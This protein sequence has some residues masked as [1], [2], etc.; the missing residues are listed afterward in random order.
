MQF[1]NIL[2][3][4]FAISF[5]NMTHSDTL[6]FQQV[7]AKILTNSVCLYYMHDFAHALMYTVCVY[8]CA[9]ARACVRVQGVNANK[10]SLVCRIYDE[11]RSVMV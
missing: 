8:L 9:I 3:A 10:E 7:K 4:V 1:S 2:Y 6:M 11:L 5:T